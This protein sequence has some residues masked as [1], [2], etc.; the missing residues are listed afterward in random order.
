LPLDARRHLQHLLALSGLPAELKI[1]AT[2]N[3]T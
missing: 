2:G 3:I 1:E